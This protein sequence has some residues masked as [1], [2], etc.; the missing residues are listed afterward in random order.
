MLFPGVHR[1][2]LP[3]VR[4]GVVPVRAA[5]GRPALRVRAVLPQAGRALRLVLP[6][7]HGALR[8]ARHVRQARHAMQRLQWVS[9]LKQFE[10][11]LLDVTSYNQNALGESS[12]NEHQTDASL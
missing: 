9:G 5:Q 10:I 4:A 11:G 2:H 12:D 3:G 8:R 1:L 6:L 7:E